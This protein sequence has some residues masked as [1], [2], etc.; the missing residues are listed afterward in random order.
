MAAPVI[1]ADALKDKLEAALEATSVTVIDTSGNC[2]ATFDVAVVS[3]QFEGKLPLAR[4]RLIM[5]ALKEEM[6]TIHA[7]SVKAA[8][9]PAQQQAA[10]QQQQQPAAGAA[11]GAAAAAPG[12]T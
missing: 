7:L 1:T 3:P 2:G 5:G 6:K 12:A 4:H 9:T 10:Q 11:T 8:W